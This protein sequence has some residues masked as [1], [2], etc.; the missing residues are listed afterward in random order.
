MAHREQR[1]RGAR[2][3]LSVGISEAESIS[4]EL[5]PSRTTVKAEQEELEPVP[6]VNIGPN[7]NEHVQ[8]AARHEEQVTNEK[9]FAQ[10]VGPFEFVIVEAQHVVNL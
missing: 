2:L 7:V 4:R 1:T 10:M 6:K 5:S 3:H 9:V 8:V